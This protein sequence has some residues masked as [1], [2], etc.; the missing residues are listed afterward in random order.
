MDRALPMHEFLFS[1][2]G[3]VVCGLLLWNSPQLPP[4]RVGEGAGG[5]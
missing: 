4:L 5:G 2:N 3:F 1:G